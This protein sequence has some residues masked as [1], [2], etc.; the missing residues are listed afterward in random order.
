MAAKAAVMVVAHPDH[1]GFVARHVW[2]AALRVA[3]W[4]AAVSTT[5]LIGTGF[6]IA[7][8]IAF[9][10]GEAY[11]SFLMGR[12]RQVHFSFGYV[13][14]IA[15]LIRGYAFFFGNNYA[16]SGFP[17]IWRKQWWGRIRE[18][19]TDYLVIRAGTRYVGHN[20]LGALTYMLLIGFL[21]VGQILTGFAMYSESNPGGFWDTMVGWVIPLCGGSWGLH[22]WH[23]L[24]AWGILLFVPI[25]IYVVV[26]D[27]ILFRNGL[28]SS[29]VMGRK[30]VRKDDVDSKT[31]IS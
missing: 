10:Q 15:F 20:Q 17:F 25:H 29:I 8:P 18:Q 31:W 24:F 1:D 26:L 6:Y 16:R 5:I 3:H 30:L 13:L 9:T 28:I 2:D 27:S 21:G 7:W 23:H 11:D 22:H 4:M 12:V 14:L 19:M